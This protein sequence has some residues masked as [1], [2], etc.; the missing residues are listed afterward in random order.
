MIYPEPYS[1]YL[2]GTIE[3]WSLGILEHQVERTMEHEMES[4]IMQ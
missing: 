2:T 4:G 3:N 1:I